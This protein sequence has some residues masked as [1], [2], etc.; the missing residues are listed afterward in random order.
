MVTIA[1][2]TAVGKTQ[3]TLSLAKKYGSD[4]FSADSRQLYKEMFIGTAKP[5]PEELELARH[6]FIDHV[7][8]QDDFNVS[9]YETE[10]DA[11]F[12]TY[13]SNH[14]IGILSGGTG[15][16]IKAALEGMDHFPEVDVAHSL[17]YESILIEEGIGSL[18]DELKRLDTEYAQKVDM[19][20]SRRLVRALSVI[21]ASGKAYSSF[22][23]KKKTKSLP[24]QTINICLERDR[25]ELYDRINRRVNQMIEDGLLDEVRSLFKYRNLRSMQTV[26]YSELFRHLEGEIGLEEAVELIKRNSR[27]Y[28][29]RQMTWFRNQGDWKYFHPEDIEEIMKYID[30]KINENG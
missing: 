30:V 21:R 10:I 15:M 7:S 12:L 24:F 19:S 2:P 13:F 3:L 11:L 27:R 1:G 14:S 26:G 16:Y 22:L 20:N 9:N 17:Y 6:H 25:E 28:A 18:Q 29:K 23:N 5:S 8:I 4:I